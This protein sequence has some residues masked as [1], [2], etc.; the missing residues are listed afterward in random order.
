MIDM[1]SHILPLVDDG[2]KSIEET[3][4]MLKEAEDANFTDIFATSHY[5]EGEYE[6]NKIDRQYIIEAIMRKIEQQ[7]INIKIHIGTEAYISPNLTKLLKNKIIATLGNSRYILF[8]LPLKAKVINIEDTINDICSLG[9]IPI[10]A[11]PERYDI[12]KENH[13]IV[14]EWVEL[15]ALIQANYASILNAYG[16]KNKTTL[17]KL[18]NADLVHFLGTDAHM[19]KSIYTKIEEI[20]KMYIKEIGEEKFNILTYQNPIMVIGNKPIIVK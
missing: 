19:Q 1:H 8:E 15:G 12:V 20:K 16:N 3:I 7:K 9:L 6:F 13:N 5:I 10:I 11:H 18:L 14:K 4:A 2:A 17:L